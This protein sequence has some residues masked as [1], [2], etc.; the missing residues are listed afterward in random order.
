MRHVVRVPDPPFGYLEPRGTV[1]FARRAS[2]LTQ[3][4]PHKSGREGWKRKREN[5]L[6]KNET[7][8]GGGESESL[9]GVVACGR[10]R[11]VFAV[12]YTG[13]PFLNPRRR[14]AGSP[15]KWE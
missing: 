13:S 1:P 4:N 7:G 9:Q 14:P 6:K 10:S 11:Q 8:R 2:N 15:G 3:T 5:A 12:G